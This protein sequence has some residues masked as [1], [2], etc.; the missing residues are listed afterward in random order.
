MGSLAAIEA[1][2]RQAGVKI[3]S[4]RVSPAGAGNED[5]VEITLGSVADDRAVR[6]LDQLRA[7]PGTR[8]ASYAAGSQLPTPGGDVGGSDEK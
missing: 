7:L 1:A 6:L 4:L 5:R 3:D 2:I 8:L